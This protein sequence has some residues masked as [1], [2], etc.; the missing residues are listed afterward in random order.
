MN[1]ELFVKTINETMTALS[2][3]KVNEEL[4]NIINNIITIMEKDILNSAIHENNIKKSSPIK[5][6]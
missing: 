4:S 2:T 3:V 5:R 1:P 6:L